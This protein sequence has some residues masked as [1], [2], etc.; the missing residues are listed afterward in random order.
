[1]CLTLLPYSTWPRVLRLAFGAHSTEVHLSHPV[2]ALDLI[3]CPEHLGLIP[4]QNVAGAHETVDSFMRCAP[5]PNEDQTHL[6]ADMTVADPL[7][8][9]VIDLWQGTAKRNRDIF[10]E[11][12]R[13]V[14][15]DL[16]H[17]WTAYKVCDLTC[18]ATCPA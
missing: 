5:H 3:H 7:S 4:P 16:V 9:R 12:F 14:P 1:M 11:V 17:N 8:D 6:R 15:S 10:T 13:P 18:A 2:Q